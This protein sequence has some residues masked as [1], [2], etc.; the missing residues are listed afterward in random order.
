[1]KRFYAVSTIVSDKEPISKVI[2]WQDAED[3]PACS[4]KHNSR[5]DYYIDWFESKEEAEE[6]VKSQQQY[7]KYE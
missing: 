5:A 7:K 4:F 2:G 6:F 3:K 1:M